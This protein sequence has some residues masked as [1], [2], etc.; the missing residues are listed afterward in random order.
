MFTLSCAQPAG[1]PPSSARGQHP[2]DARVLQGCG[3]PFPP[4]SVMRQST[5]TYRPLP[6]A[7][8][9]IM[10]CAVRARGERSEGGGGGGRGGGGRGRHT[11]TNLSHSLPR[12]RLRPSRPPLSSSP[13]MLTQA[14]CRCT[15]WTPEPVTTVS[16]EKLGQGG[17][18]PSLDRALGPH[19]PPARY[20]P[21]SPPTRA[22][23]VDARS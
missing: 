22:C 19:P 13:P 23:A 11:E 7:C 6:C 2:P 10:W 21:F 16:L 15:A 18:R 8:T 14:P 1:S 12:P 9:K 4:S 20:T 3:A 5:L 17:G